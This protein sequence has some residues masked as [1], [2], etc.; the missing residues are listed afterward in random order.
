[1]A[2]YITLDGKRYLTTDLAYQP[3]RKKAQ[4]INLGLTGKTISQTF[5]YSDYTWAVPIL[6]EITPADPEFGSEDDLETAYAKDYVTFIDRDETDQGYV[7]MLGNLAKPRKFALM[8]ESASYKTV[9][10]L[11]KRQV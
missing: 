11:R 9:L 4:Q 7:F 8:D 3:E 1:M 10:Q 6:V 2:N 5:D